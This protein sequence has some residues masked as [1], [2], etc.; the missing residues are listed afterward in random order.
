MTTMHAMQFIAHQKYNIIKVKA[1]ENK[2]VNGND[3]KDIGF[4]LYNLRLFYNILCIIVV[5]TF[6]SLLNFEI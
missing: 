6:Y 5:T 3:M 4:F 1:P 2:V